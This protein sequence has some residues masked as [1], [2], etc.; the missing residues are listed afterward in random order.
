[1]LFEVDVPFTSWARLTPGRKWIYAQ[2][3]RGFE[4]VDTKDGTSAGTILFDQDWRKFDGEFFGRSTIDVDSDGRRALLV[5]PNRGNSVQIIPVDL[6]KGSLGTITRYAYRPADLVGNMGLGNLASWASDRYIRFESGHI[7]DALTG[8]MAFHYSV[9]WKRPSCVGYL[10]NRK[11]WHTIDDGNREDFAALRARF[12]TPAKSYLVSTQL[13]APAEI[14]ASGDFGK[15]PWPIGTPLRV[16]AG[17]PGDVV[18]QTEVVELVAEAFAKRGFPI[19]PTA[20]ARVS[21]TTGPIAKDTVYANATDG[22]V[23]SAAKWNPNLKNN[24]GSKAYFKVEKG[25]VGDLFVETFDADGKR[26]SLTLHCHGEVV[27]YNA[28]R[29][30]DKLSGQLQSQLESGELDKPRYDPANRARLIGQN[31]P[32]KLEGIAK[33]P[34]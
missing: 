5:V 15:Y 8:E 25:L 3:R 31:I 26:S 14:A 9:K 17:G 10:P 22:D 27:G 18:H 6:E 13:P 2:T 30:L 33:P 12:P 20:K 11:A 24:D 1:M 16:E 19:D 4:F 32:V 23:K 7:F 34:G 21:V 28:K 29:L